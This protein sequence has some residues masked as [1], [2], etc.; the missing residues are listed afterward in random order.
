MHVRRIFL[1]RSVFFFGCNNEKKNSQRRWSMAAESFENKKKS[2]QQNFA[3]PSK[4]INLIVD[5]Y[6][7]LC[8]SSKCPVFFYGIFKINFVRKKYRERITPK[9]IKKFVW[10]G[11]LNHMFLYH[12]SFP[13][14]ATSSVSLSFARTQKMFTQFVTSWAQCLEMYAAF[15]LWFSLS[16]V[17]ESF[18][19]SS[20]RGNVLLCKNSSPHFHKWEKRSVGISQ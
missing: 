10:K 16:L 11:L 5:V 4:Y 14:I 18:L 12:C 6:V 17:C 19:N 1:L 8:D 9:K 13:F 15:G 7:C 3:K 2:Q 20:K